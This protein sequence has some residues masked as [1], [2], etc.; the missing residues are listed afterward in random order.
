MEQKREETENKQ[1]RKK[2]SEEKQQRLM[3]V[4]L[5]QE[6]ALNGCRRRSECSVIRHS[7]PPIRMNQS[8]KTAGEKR[9]MSFCLVD[10]FQGDHVKVRRRGWWSDQE[11]WHP[12]RKSECEVS[13]KVHLFNSIRISLLFREPHKWWGELG[14]HPAVWDG[15]QLGSLELFRLWTGTSFT[16]SFFHVFHL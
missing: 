11:K 12:D 1:N 16:W 15:Y 10:S 14:N 9:C 7:H 6:L 13:I 4:K 8:Q 5:L 2:R 3:K